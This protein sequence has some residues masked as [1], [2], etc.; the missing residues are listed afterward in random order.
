MLGCIHRLIQL[1]LSK[2]E[3]DSNL[4]RVLAVLLTL[5]RLTDVSR[6]W[7]EIC[8]GIGPLYEWESYLELFSA[9]SITFP[10]H[11]RDTLLMW[12]CKTFVTDAEMH[13]TFFSDGSLYTDVA[14][15]FAQVCNN[16]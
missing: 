12:L 13:G 6:F 11:T 9:F 16:R 4:R 1:N 8:H 7:D 2:L 3:I 5:H 15:L 14:L 10:V